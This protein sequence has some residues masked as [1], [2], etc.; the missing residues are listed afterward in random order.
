MIKLTQ[1]RKRRG[2]ARN[3]GCSGLRDGG[4]RRAAK[5]MRWDERWYQAPSV[6]AASSEL[7]AH[8]C[9]STLFHFLHHTFSHA[10]VQTPREITVCARVCACV[11]VT[12]R[13]SA[14][15][16]KENTE[17]EREQ[18]CFPSYSAFYLKID[19]GLIKK[20]KASVWASD[21]CC[22]N[23]KSL[24]V[25]YNTEEAT[26]RLTK[27]LNHSTPQWKWPPQKHN[28]SLSLS[29]R[30]PPSFFISYFI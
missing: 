4:D 2:Y 17:R 5:E 21:L 18:N 11:C 12:E 20:K 27:G 22:S 1:S 8:H 28:P 15:K 3:A 10:E 14:R 16:T 7:P 30:C 6:W 9:C 23:K 19:A 25:L 24:V 13:E 26:H 29:P